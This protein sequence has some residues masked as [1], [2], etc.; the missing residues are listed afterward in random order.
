MELTRHLKDDPNLPA[1]LT[2]IRDS[3]AYM[4]G[5]IDPPSSMHHMTL[6]SLRADAE[7][8]EIWS[9]GP[10][11]SACVVLS[12][13]P[14]TLYI[15]KLCVAKHARGTG[16]AHH[17]IQHAEHRARALRLPTLTLEVRIELTANHASFKAMGFNEVARTAHQGYP[18]PTSIT[19]QK[20]I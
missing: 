5:I 19:F 9:L 18:H 1:I 15:G 4:D 14:N 20:E 3:F 11:L 2:L 8:R 7:T 17:L 13:K 6:D 12:P 16:L 10:P